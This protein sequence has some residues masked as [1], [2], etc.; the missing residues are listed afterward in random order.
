MARILTEEERRAKE[1]EKRMIKLAMSYKKSDALLKKYEQA[2]KA[3]RDEIEKAMNEEGVTKANVGIFKLSIL[4]YL[5]PRFDSARF[6]A[7]NE[8]LAALYTKDHKVHEV[9][10]N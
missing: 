6:K 8:A 4:D 7:E 1:W 10:V 9:R 2:K 3:A 5:S